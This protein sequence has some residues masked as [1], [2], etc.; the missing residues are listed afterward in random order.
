M[1][2][3]LEGDRL[4]RRVGFLALHQVHAQVL[5]VGADELRFAVADHAPRDEYR[6]GVAGAERLETV[7]VAAE[8]RGDVR[9]EEFAVDLHLGLQR[10]RV[11][12]LFDVGIEAAGE[13]LD[14][15]GTHR[16]SCC[17]HVPAEVLQ[18]VRTGFDCLIEVEAG[19]RAGRTRDE[20]VAHR[21]HHRRA[22]V[23]FDQAGGHDAHDALHPA[24]VV[25][26]RTLGGLQ[27]RVGLDEVVGFLR[28][29]AVDALAVLVEAVDHRAELFGQAFVAFDQQ[30]DRRIA[31]RRSGVFVV[32]VHPHTACGVDAGS[33]FEDDVVDGDVVSI[34][35]ADLDDREQP[36]RGGGV[37]P[38]KPVVG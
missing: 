2:R 36:L 13:L 26:H 15:F 29:A 28:D 37:E 20:P 23:G 10:Y 19:H 16:E 3:L 22:V 24:G 14:P 21:E 18:Q 9:E 12:V 33:D 17:V 5:A 4:N 8:R 38:Q 7:Q 31:A 35:A 11:D 25:D 1:G 27:L 6:C 34:Q 32:F 30:I